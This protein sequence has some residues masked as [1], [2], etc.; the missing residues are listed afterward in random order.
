MCKGEQ[1]PAKGSEES[2]QNNQVLYELITV[3]IRSMQFSAQVIDTYV[4]VVSSRVWEK[5]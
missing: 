4:V 2:E 3:Y 1:D 5:I